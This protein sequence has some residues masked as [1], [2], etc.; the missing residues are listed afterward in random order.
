MDFANVKLEDYNG[1]HIFQNNG[2]Y[3]NKNIA[4][5][6]DLSKER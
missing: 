6:I 2:S 1:K 5:Y 3:Q 4:Q